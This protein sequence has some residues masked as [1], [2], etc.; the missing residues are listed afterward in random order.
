MDI[1][2]QVP[3]EF[4]KV[5]VHQYQKF[6]DHVCVHLGKDI[7]LN[8]IG[9]NPND[10]NIFVK[11]D[12]QKRLKPIVITTIKII[13]DRTSINTIFT[14][15]QSYICHFGFNTHQVRNDEKLF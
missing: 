8:Q 13:S 9:K 7:T 4:H 1:L 2:S 15:N 6:L 12:K 14:I 11:G 3:P 5:L 10:N